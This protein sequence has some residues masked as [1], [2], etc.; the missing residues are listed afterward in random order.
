MLLHELFDKSSTKIKHVSKPT[1]TTAIH[2]QQQDILGVGYQTVT[3]FREKFPGKVVKWAQ[4]TGTSDPV[5]QFLR[6]CLNNQ[7][8]PYLPR[9]YKAKH[10]SDPHKNFDPNTFQ[11]DKLEDEIYTI[12]P[13]THKGVVIYVTEKLKHLTN[14]D[15]KELSYYG[16]SEESKQQ[17]LNTSW[18]KKVQND[19]KVNDLM[20]FSLAF[21]YPNIRKEMKNATVD[22]HFKNVLRLLEPMFNSYRIDT[23]VNNFMC[24]DN[25]HLVF[26]D[27]VSYKEDDDL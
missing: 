7:N 6:L 17:L 14:K 11:N 22:P 16:I 10:Y 23:H 5:Y 13:K 19:F 9:I 2:H 26:I 4:I 27:P 24:R 3:Y 25:G 18:I 8:N 21:Q 15:L 1:A 20:I 12:M